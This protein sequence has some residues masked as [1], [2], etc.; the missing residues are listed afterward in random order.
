MVLDRLRELHPDLD[1]RVEPNSALANKIARTAQASRF[2]TRL[3]LAEPRALKVLE[4]CDE[5][6]VPG[7]SVD[8]LVKWKQLELLRIAARDLDG[9]DSLEVVAA[10]LAT[11][12]EDVIANALRIAQAT[13]SLS[14]I[15][16]GKLGGKELNYASDIDVMFV[17]EP[18]EPAARRVMEIA[19]KC[20]RV[21]A[22]LRPE[23]RDGPLVR[24]VDSYA[25]YW[26][27]WASTWEFQ[28]LLKAR[29]IAGNAQ[30]GDFWAA[31][32]SKNLWKRSFGADE[33]REIRE[34]KARSESIVEQKG[35]ADRE[36]KR[37]RGG[38]RD[39]EFSV[40]LL[41]L[42]HGS[43]DS[44]IRSANTLIALQQL[45]DGGY[46]A[47]DD[48]VVLSG[49]YRFLRNVE[50]RLQLV[51]EE[52]THTIPSNVGEQ[53]ALARSLG[54]RD[55]PRTRAVDN[56]MQE[57]RAHQT[58]VRSSHKRL[59]F[60]PLLEAFASGAGKQSTA[61][62]E[63]LA[64]FGFTDAERTRQAVKELT[65]GLARSS[66][67]MDQMMPL[68]LDW[69]SASPD[70]DAG[71]FGLRTLTAGFRT[72]VQ[73]VSIFR[74]SP[75]VARRL[76]MLLGTSRLF[77]NGFARHPELLSDL[78]GDKDLAP[79]ASAID[80][81]RMARAWMRSGEA[82]HEALLRFTRAEQL[83]IAAADVLGI[84]GETESGRRRTELADAVIELA[85]EDIE[86]QIPVAVIGMGRFGGREM[87]YASDLDVIVVHGGVNAQ[88]QAIAESIAQQLLRHIGD[89]SPAKQLYPL[90]YDLRPEGKKGVL[91]RSIEG[92][93]D[94][95]ANWAET[96][97]R[98][99]LVRA[100][101]VAGSQDVIDD[102]MGI[103]H[104]FVWERD[105]SAE[106]RRQIRHLKARMEQ[107][108]VSR[109]ENV[110]LDLKLGHGSLSDV[111]WTV[112]LLQLEHH[113]ESTNTLDALDQLQAGRFIDRPRLSSA[114][115]CLALLQQRSQSTVFGQWWSRR[116]APYEPRK[117]C[118]F[119]AQPGGN[120]SRV[121]R[122]TSKS[123]SALSR[124]NGTSFLWT[125]GRMTEITNETGPEGAGTHTETNDEVTVETAQQ[126]K[127]KKR[128]W[129][130]TALAI[131]GAIALVPIAIIAIARLLS[132][133]TATLVMAQSLIFYRVSAGVCGLGVFSY[134]QTE[135]AVS[136]SWLACDLPRC[137]GFARNTSSFRTTSRCCIGS[138]HQALYAKHVV[139]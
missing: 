6:P 12:A 137:L 38:I 115:Q 7:E 76:C 39:I 98:Q 126:S 28:A 33:L 32:A 30:F 51:E 26:Q 121:E 73:I 114:A 85:L 25:N 75:E 125:G 124:I 138:A 117:T 61:V 46:I 17:G 64:A 106:E 105:V 111:E 95:Y 108:R 36:V 69:L 15:G 104:G 20:F 113:I 136:R 5:R 92:C 79:E 90:D 13:D 99:A 94:Y 112:Q 74:D 24:T 107:E 78:A 129:L 60:R 81:C 47:S 49:S 56:M 54:F 86:P 29:P 58:V 83:R 50:H 91:A 88:Q 135:V 134:H 63:R 37:G 2:L 66:R 72:P 128:H 1:K 44:T 27:Q 45:A 23:G 40:Q 118:L 131:V 68:L 97:E 35:L 52:Q 67:L 9:T 127:G 18:N 103:V 11:L 3:L 55:T 70:P 77:A 57:L 4:N 96:W 59:Y 84:I 42:V 130:S 122:A 71:L 14:V 65:R 10:N 102:F 119:G 109:P 110:Q 93:R 80:R 120:T 21:D 19:R 34:M 101:P 123:D 87:S 132:I 139:Q 53:E 48:A 41:Q 22:N 89:T 82:K 8:D 31:E 133:E 16:M 62:T 116:F 100:R 43:N